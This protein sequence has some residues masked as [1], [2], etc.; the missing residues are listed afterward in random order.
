MASRSTPRR[1][2]CPRPA[3]RRS[4]TPSSLLHPSHERRGVAYGTPGYPV[5]D[6]APSSPAGTGAVRLK[7]GQ[8]SAQGRRAGPAEHQGALDQLPHNPTGATAPYEYLEKVAAF[9]REHDVFSS[10]TSATTTSTQGSS[11]LDPRDNP[12]AHARLLLLPAQRHDRL[13]RG[14]DGRR[15]GAHR[16]PQETAPLHR[17]RH[18][19]LRAG[20]RDRRLERRR[21]RRERR[22]IF[23]EKRELFKDF[24]ERAG[25]GYLPTDASIYLWVRYPTFGT[26]RRTP[27]A[28]WRKASSW[29]RDVRSVRAA[30]ATCRVALVPR[31]RSAGRR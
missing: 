9:C 31:R 23:A 19:I 26:T 7:L 20:R 1:R 18:P 14:D 2:S 22:R 29:R 17:R 3:P 27:C 15:C 6:G 30:R 25:L 5:Y 11:A 10:P 4:S 28:C 16:R 13:P 8:L 12:R 24:F 21:A